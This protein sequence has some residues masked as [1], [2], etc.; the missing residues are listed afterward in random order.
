MVPPRPPVAV[1]ANLSA[2]DLLDNALVGDVSSLLRRYGS[3]P[4]GS[5]SK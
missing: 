1:A 3:P 4:A 5:R 2:T